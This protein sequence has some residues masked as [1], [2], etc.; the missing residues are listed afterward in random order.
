MGFPCSLLAIVLLRCVC[1]HT[2][3]FLSVSPLFAIYE[4][5]AAGRLAS[6]REKIR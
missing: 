1:T 3:L 5:R 4:K 6:A 2:I